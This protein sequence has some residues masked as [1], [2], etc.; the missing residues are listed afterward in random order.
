MKAGRA[1][2]RMFKRT[3]A[4]WTRRNA[5]GLFQGSIAERIETWR[6]LAEFEVEVVMQEW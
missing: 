4:N 6:S 1:V 3:R 2:E 5:V